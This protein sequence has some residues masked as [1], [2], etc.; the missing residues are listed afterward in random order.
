MR[1]VSSERLR[2][3]AVRAGAVV[4]TLGVQSLLLKSVVRFFE[5]KAGLPAEYYPLFVSVL[6]ALFLVV[7]MSRGWNIAHRRWLPLVGVFVGLMAGVVSYNAVEAATAGGAS[8]Y[9]DYLRMLHERSTALALGKLVRP[10]FVLLS[11]IH[12]LLL[13]SVFWGLLHIQRGLRS[14]MEADWV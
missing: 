2:Y 5:R 1:F 3:E 11:P 4:V 13:F 10:P 7:T 8:A 14:Q 12:G 6:V 9:I